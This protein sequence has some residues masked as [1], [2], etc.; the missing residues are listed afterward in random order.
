MVQPAAVEAAILASEEQAQKQDQVVAALERDLE[1]ARYASRRAQKHFDAAV[2]EN[3]LVTDELERR[4]NQ[5][6]QH[7]QAGGTAGGLSGER[8]FALDAEGFR[9]AGII[10]RLVTHSRTTCRFPN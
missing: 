5:T 8:I 4:W 10:P 2:P 7:V 3:R 9:Q 1:A 6:L